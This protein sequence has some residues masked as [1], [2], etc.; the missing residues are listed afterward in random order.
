MEETQE[1]SFPGFYYPED[2]YFT[3]ITNDCY[4]EFAKID[5]IAELKIIL[6]I[7]RHTWGFQEYDKWKEISVDE[8]MYGRYSGDE[9]LDDG[10]RLSE[11][12]VRNGLSKAI[13]HGYVL[14]K[15]IARDRARIRKFYKL[16]MY[17][18]K[19]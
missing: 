19:Q 17:P 9:R 1:S 3:R 11:Q 14:E 8:F 13:K 16:K 10:T 12:S 7:A 5:N 4:I 18:R 2:D 15:V 6:Y